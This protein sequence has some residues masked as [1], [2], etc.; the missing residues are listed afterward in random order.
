M[1]EEEKSKQTEGSWAWLVCFASFWTNGTVFGIL[2]SFG[3]LLVAMLEDPTLVESGADAFK[4]SWI[5]SIA[6]GLVFMISPV[7]G[8]MVD[9]IGGRKTALIGAVGAFVGCLASSFAKALWALFLSYGCLLGIGFSLVYTPSLV[10]L[11]QYFDKRLGRANGVATAGSGVFTIFIPILMRQTSMKLGLYH[12]LRIISLLVF[13]LILCALTFKTP[14]HPPGSHETEDCDNAEAKKIKFINPHIWKLRN[15]RLWCLAIPIASLGYFV[16]FFHL[17]NYVRILLPDAHGT[18]LIVLLGATSLIGRYLFGHISDYP[19][20]KKIVNRVELQQLSM[21]AIGLFSMLVPTL[22]LHFSAL[23]VAILVM[24]LFDGCYVCM[25]GPVAVDIVGAKN[26]SQAVGF[27]L[28]LMALPM[29]AGPPLAGLIYENTGSY[30]LAFILAGVPPV[31]GAFIM[32]FIK[33][34]DEKEK[35]ARPSVDR[36]KNSGQVALLRR[37]PSEPQ[38]E[39]V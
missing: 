2:N 5:G 24:G 15:Y 16:P 30:N 29:T 9:A 4:T 31:I 23:A 11:S 6:I 32:C 35:R 13:L 25:I 37:K 33:L 39:P 17:I 36:R 18:I 34:E 1:G 12:T 3:V 27:L 26:A 7:A 10:I 21:I 28:G 20:V 8:I 19:R 38:A 14:E 22:V